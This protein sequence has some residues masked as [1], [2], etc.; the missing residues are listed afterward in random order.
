VAEEEAYWAGVADGT[1]VAGCGPF[2]VAPQGK[3]GATAANRRARPSKV[4]DCGL[5][6][7]QFCDKRKTLARFPMRLIMT[8]KGVAERKL[9]AHCKK[10]AIRSAHLRANGYMRP[11]A[12]DII[13][14]YHA[15]RR[16]AQLELVCFT[17][18]CCCEQC[19]ACTSLQSCLANTLE[20][21]RAFCM[22]KPFNK[23]N[24]S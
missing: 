23:A 22:P 5:K 16:F 6:Q 1:I 17:T 7:C 10:C 8:C 19:I 14:A 18:Q 12:Q 3:G 4:D 13:K 15:V 20:V 2:G 21:P 11:Q 24:V 9:G